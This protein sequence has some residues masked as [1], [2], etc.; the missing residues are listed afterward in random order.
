MYWNGDPLGG[1]GGITTVDNGLN[2]SPAGNARLGGPLVVD[3]NIN[4]QAFGP[5]SYFSIDGGNSG[6]IFELNENTNTWS[7]YSGT[8]SLTLGSSTSLMI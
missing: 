7:L 4:V 8:A 5:G 1:G 6:G 3:T 2:E